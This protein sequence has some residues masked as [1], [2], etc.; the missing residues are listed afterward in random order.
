MIGRSNAQR[1]A[2]QAF[3][4][5]QIKL[6]NLDIILT[7]LDEVS[8]LLSVW[9]ASSNLMS[10]CHADICGDVPRSRGRKI[11][12]RATRELFPVVVVELMTV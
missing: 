3:G 2:R 8:T 4:A 5:A 12:F 10:F 1:A 7:I 11:D 9:Y 6:L